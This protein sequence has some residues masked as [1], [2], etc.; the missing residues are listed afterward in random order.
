MAKRKTQQ[1]QADMTMESSETP[2][3]PRQATKTTHETRPLRCALTDRE[4]IAAGRKLAEKCAELQRTEDDRKSVASSYKA[5]IDRMVAERNELVD[6]VEKGE[7]I[8]QVACTLTLDYDTLTATVTRD[9]TGEVIEERALSE[10]EKQMSF[11]FDG[12][13][14][15]DTPDSPA[16]WRKDLVD[17]YGRATVTEAEDK[18]LTN[19]ARYRDLDSRGDDGDTE[20]AL[21]ACKILATALRDTNVPEIE[22][23][24]DDAGN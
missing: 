7:E 8:R 10:A 9:D 14:D 12:G 11:T 22:G 15:A 2:P 24:A 18:L 19:S 17:Q 20:A 21:E 13:G 5:Q 3:E 16:K 4:R 1:Q 6:R 23:D